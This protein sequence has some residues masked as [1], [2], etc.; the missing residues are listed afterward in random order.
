M[1]S[2]FKVL[3]ER[4]KPER[5]TKFSAM[6]DLRANADLTIAAGETK[7]V[8]L[9]VIIDLD[10]LAHN[11]F[12]KLDRVNVLNGEVYFDKVVFEEYLKTHY[13]QL[14]PRSSLRAKGLICSPYQI[15]DDDT[16]V[17]K[18]VIDLDYTKELGL[19]VHYPVTEHHITWWV[20]KVLAMCGINKSFN[21]DNTANYHI[22]KGDKIAQCTILAHEGDLMGIES[23]VERTDGFGSTGK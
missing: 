20:D 22:K 11:L 5:G 14:E 18:G 2:I 19:I 17:K 23:D 7:I 3:D 16:I 13:I 1:K 6:V 21:L 8:P 4:C 9:G 10:A 12:T 15:E